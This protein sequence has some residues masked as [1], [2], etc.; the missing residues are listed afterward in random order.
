MGCSCQNKGKKPQWEVVVGG[1]VVFGPSTSKGTVDTVAKKYPGS[2]VR[3]TAKPST[4]A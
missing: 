4:T 3:S 2:E 1:K